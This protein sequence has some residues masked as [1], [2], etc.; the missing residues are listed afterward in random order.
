MVGNP[1][2]KTTLKFTTEENIPLE[3]CPRGIPRP[4]KIAS[5][6]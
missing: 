1:Q 4:L 3:K 5:K 2:E 6:E